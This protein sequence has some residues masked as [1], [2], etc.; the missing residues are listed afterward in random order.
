VKHTQ[1]F[2]AVFMLLGCMAAA[3]TD[4]VLILHVN[5]THSNL[6]PS[7]PRD[8]ALAQKMGGLSRAVAYVESARIADPELLLLHAGDF[9]VGDLMY[10][11]LFGMVEL[12]LLED[13]GVDAMTLGNHEFDL[14]AF[15]L[16]YVLDSS[17]VP[18]P[19]LSA[20]FVRQ[21]PTL[22]SLGSRVLPETVL[23]VKGRKIG[24]FGLT[25]P[26]TNMLSNA[27]PHVVFADDSI[28]S[29]AAAAVASLRSQG[30]EAV[31]LLSHLGIGGDQLI[32]GLVPGIDLI[33][34]GHDHIAMD[35][36]AYFD[37]PLGGQTPVVQ[38]GAFYHDVGVARLLIDNT[39][40]SLL[41]WER[42]PLDETVIEDPATA[43]FLDFM[44]MMIEDAF[45]IPLFSAS[46]ATISA[47]LDE[48]AG[49]LLAG[50]PHD[51]PVGNLVTDAFRAYTGTEVAV[52]AG[53]STAQ[54][55]YMG[56]VTT[57]DIFRMIGYGMN[58]DNMLGF[59]LATFD[60]SGAGLLS[61]LEFG[62]S[63]IELNDEFLMQSSGLEYVYDP[64]A[65]VFQRLLYDQVTIGGQPV[66]PMR[67]YT[68]TCNEFV[69]MIFD[70]ILASS[71]LDTLG[72]FT[73]LDVTELEAVSDYL[74]SAGTYSPVRRNSVVAP[75]ERVASRPETAA[76]L[77]HH[78]NPVRSRTSRIFDL[79]AGGPVEMTLY[80]MDGRRISTFVNENLAPGR[81][82]RSLD[83]SGLPPGV[84]TY[85]MRSGDGI[86]TRKLVKVR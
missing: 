74:H 1:R 24:V 45:S 39:G 15:M 26:E 71:G 61:G 66:D 42:A 37:N 10:N 55:L 80:G 72:N 23:E 40:A 46:V 53:G 65:D 8:A 38:A 6:L 58:M 62:L 70:M 82:T 60:V 22:A 79:R 51:T 28:P 54:P 14:G 75:V 49:A 83:V 69:A 57:N 43:G 36:P 35:A 32:A 3:Q 34:G 12:M 17:G 84:Y 9:A 20:N 47:T 33:I 5:D 52:T 16:E 64:A 67:R 85:S 44:A 86:R 56:P 18:F 25:T 19:L 4:T 13:L 76:V 78:P 48:Q 77:G 50:G 7:G 63:Q 31:I 11:T 59:K 2:L 27:Y 30:C 81:H 41:D 29:L 21:E 68:V 73:L